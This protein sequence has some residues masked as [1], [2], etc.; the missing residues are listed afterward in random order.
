MRLPEFTAE[1]SLGKTREAYFL[2][3]H[4]AAD[5]G[6]A[7]RPQGFVIRHW[8]NVIYFAYCDQSGCYY[9]QVINPHVLM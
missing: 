2:L 7:V 1:A 9:E 6:S 3:P 8:G 5:T 4:V